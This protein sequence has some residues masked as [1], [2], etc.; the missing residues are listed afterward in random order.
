MIK[1]I[2][3]RLN[4][5]NKQL[6]KLFQYAGCARFAYNWAI[7]R[8][9]ETIGSTMMVFTNDG[10]FLYE[11]HGNNIK[12][13]SNYCNPKDREFQKF[14]Y[15]DIDKSYYSTNKN[16]V[17][18]YDDNLKC[19]YKLKENI[20]NN[21]RNKLI[22]EIK[23]KSDDG[24]ILIIQSESGVPLLIFSGNKIENISDISDNANFYKF[25]IDNKK[26]FLYNVTFEIIDKSLIK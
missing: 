10:N 16:S 9:E 13:T 4:P 11:F 6:T 21:N 25:K 14:L 20:A 3:V 1:A 2:K 15:V 26:I 17:I 12:V 18:V 7:S 8:E 24:L 23:N 5:N 22:N 19:N